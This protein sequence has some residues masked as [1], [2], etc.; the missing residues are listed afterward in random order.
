M[1]WHR[2]RQKKLDTIIELQLQLIEKVEKLMTSQQDVDAAVTAVQG[3]LTDVQTQVTAIATDVTAI[4]QLLANGQTVDT[5]A[6]DSVVATVQGVQSS[7][8][9]GVSQLNALANPAPA[10]PPAA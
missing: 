5:T 4:Q 10:T 8:D 9:Q 6:L 1:V 7:L 3:L 2:E